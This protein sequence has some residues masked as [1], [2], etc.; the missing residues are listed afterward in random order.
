MPSTYTP[1]DAITLVRKYC[2]DV[3]VTSI[4]SQVCD[5]IHSKIW[6]YYPWR[7]SLSALTAI[8]IADGDQ[9]LTLNIA[10]AGFFRLMAARIVRTDTTPDEILPDL[11]IRNT[12][13]PTTVKLGY[14]AIQAIAHDAVTGKLRL[15]HA[16]QVSSETLELRGEFQRQP[17]K[18]A[19]AQ[20]GTAF[21][22]PDVYFGAFVEGLKWKLYEFDGNRKAGAIT[23]TK[24]GRIAY[25]GQLGVFMGALQDL[26]AAED[27]AGQ[28]MLVPDVPLGAREW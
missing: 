9:D 7:W 12:L 2:R 21:A 27:Y 22:F 15:D 19:D 20:L 10:D 3:P 4:D 18:I 1:N 5:I 17:T 23:V 16:V 11:D 26:A 13:P 24:D 8:A 14:P 6:I 25:S 28:D